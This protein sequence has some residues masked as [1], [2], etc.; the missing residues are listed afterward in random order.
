M[1]YFYLLLPAA[2][3]LASCTLGPDFQL[4]GASGGTKWKEGQATSN[5]RLP[6]NWW[7]LFNDRELTR[8]VDR[9]LTANN[10]QIGRAHV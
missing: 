1:K 9:A 5:A 2:F 3:A 8:L 4:P 7:R 10:D 6:D